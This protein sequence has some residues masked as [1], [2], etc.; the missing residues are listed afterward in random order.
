MSIFIVAA[1]VPLSSTCQI[2]AVRIVLATDP[3]SA[4]V[5]LLVLLFPKT[6]KL[7]VE[8]VRCLQSW[9]TH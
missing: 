2:R 8:R 4:V 6:A 5:A 1:T 3:K 7:P 9:L